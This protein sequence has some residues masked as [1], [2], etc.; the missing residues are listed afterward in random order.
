ME[1]I[2]KTALDFARL[3]RD[4]WVLGWQM[5]ILAFGCPEPPLPWQPWMP[6]FLEVL[7]ETGN[8]SE[9]IRN[10]SMSR[11]M[12]YEYRDRCQRFHAEWAAA[13][14]PHAKEKK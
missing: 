5:W 7:G 13:L 6:R 2:D 11:K 4:F 9:A 12:I 14:E 3:A 10:V 8:V 1:N